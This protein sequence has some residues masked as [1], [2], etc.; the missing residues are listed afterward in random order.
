LVFFLGSD[1]DT[2]SFRSEWPIL[3]WFFTQFFFFCSF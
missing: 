3:P 1:H 2:S